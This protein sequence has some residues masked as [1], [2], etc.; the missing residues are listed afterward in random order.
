[1]C[2]ISDGR[3]NT[4]NNFIAVNENKTI[5][6]EILVD[7]RALNVWAALTEPGLIGKWVLDTPIEILTEWLEGGYRLERGDLHG[8][9]FENRGKIVRFDPPKALEYTHWSTLSIIPDLPENYSNLRFD[10]ENTGNQT[11]LSLT[12]HNLPTFEIFKHMEF[13]WKTALHMLKEVAESR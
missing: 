11:L 10:L 12:I 3:S 4:I 5:R 13:Y 8:L 2:Y 9:A 6:L 1:M 7:A